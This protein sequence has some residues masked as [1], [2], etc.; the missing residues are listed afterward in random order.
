MEKREGDQ[1]VLIYRGLRPRT[2]QVL[3]ALSV[4]TNM[5]DWFSLPQF[6]H[7]GRKVALR[8]GKDPTPVNVEVFEIR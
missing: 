4:E 5:E 7:D 2:R 1:W 8:V 6:S 3:G